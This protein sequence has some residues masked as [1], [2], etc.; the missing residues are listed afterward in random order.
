[1]GP[2]TLQGPGLVLLRGRIGSD[3][4]PLPASAED[5]LWWP[6]FTSFRPPELY[7]SIYT[8]MS[9]LYIE[10]ERE[11]E[12]ER[13]SERERAMREREREREMEKQMYT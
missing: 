12:R 2:W 4:S 3:L 10:R 1:M 8:Y 6:G 9:R 11:R 13:E 5:L 7:L